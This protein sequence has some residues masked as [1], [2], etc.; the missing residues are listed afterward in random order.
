MKSILFIRDEITY[1]HLR[2]DIYS[3]LPKFPKLMKSKILRYLSR[4]IDILQDGR[5]VLIEEQEIQS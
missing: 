5:R 3:I 4:S 2:L 1:I